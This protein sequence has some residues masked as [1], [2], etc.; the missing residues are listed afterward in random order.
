M[1]RLRLRGITFDGLSY[2]EAIQLAIVFYEQS[3]PDEMARNRKWKDMA[4]KMNIEVITD[5]T[6]E[7]QRMERAL[8]V[9]QAEFLGD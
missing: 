9:A 1:G 3:F 6:L 5:E 8:A 2:R 7:K 4:A